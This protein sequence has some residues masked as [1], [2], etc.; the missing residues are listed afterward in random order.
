MRVARQDRAPGFTLIELI[1]TLVMASILA[2][3][4][5]P[6]LG[7]TFARS[8]LPRIWLQDAYSLQTV[9][10]NII[11][12]HTGTLDDLS[13][14]IGTEGSSQANSFG[15][16]DV[17]HNRFVGFDG[18]GN[19]TTAPGT[20]NLLKVSVQNDLGDVLTRVRYSGD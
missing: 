7:R 17:I 13:A 15:S 14:A 5:L 18:G 4:F 10:E 3:M 16:Y 6:Y 2:A 19:E 9:M 20:N 11:S 8:H 1:I 12:A